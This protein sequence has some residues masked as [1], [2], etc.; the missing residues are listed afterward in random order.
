ML[1]FFYMK[2]IPG[3]YTKI[4]KIIFSNEHIFFI[5]FIQCNTLILILNVLHH[6]VQFRYLLFKEFITFNQFESFASIE[7][8]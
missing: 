4:N 7:I 8:L 2:T 3:I 6:V 5:L 1:I